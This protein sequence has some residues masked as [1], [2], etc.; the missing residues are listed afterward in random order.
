M[1]NVEVAR[2]AN[3]YDVGGLK[4]TISEMKKGP[5]QYENNWP[6]K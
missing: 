3:V 4:L 5:K 6:E 1:Q 2:N